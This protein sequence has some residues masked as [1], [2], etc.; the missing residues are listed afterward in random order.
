MPDMN[1]YLMHGYTMLMFSSRT[2]KFEDPFK[3][4]RKSQ[5]YIIQVATRTARASFSAEYCM[6]FSGVEN[7]GFC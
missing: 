3:L 6:H 1:E 7:D 4:S 2:A 5:S